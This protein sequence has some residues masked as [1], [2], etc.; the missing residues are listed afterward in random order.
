MALA[1]ILML[2]VATS[3][4]ALTGFMTT[5]TPAY[6]QAKPKPKAS[7][8]SVFQPVHELARSATSERPG[9]Q[10]TLLRLIKHSHR[11]VNRPSRHVSAV[12]T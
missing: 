1:V 6:A 8:E 10:P 9:L 7:S 2:A 5:S 11:N 3:A 4:V 12:T